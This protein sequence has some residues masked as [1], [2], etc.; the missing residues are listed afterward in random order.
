ETSG[1]LEALDTE[2]AHRCISDHP[3][4]V[5]A[6][7]PGMVRVLHALLPVLVLS[8]VSQSF[9]S[10][11]HYPV[12][13]RN[14][15]QFEHL[16]LHPEPELG[17]IYV[18]A[19]DR[20]FR[21]SSD[22]HLEEEVKTGP[23][24]DSRECLP[25]ISDTSCPLA[26]PTSNH[27]KLLL[28]DP[29]SKVLISCGSVHQGTC[30]KRDLDAIGSV[31]FLA[32]RP[33]DTQ[34]V[35]ANDPEVS[36]VGLVVPPHGARQ[37]V[38]YVGRGYTSS[39]PPISTRNLD[40]EPIFS[41]EETAKLTVVGRLSEYDHHFVA[42][43]A[44]NSHVYFLFYRRDLKS[45]GRDYQT[46][47]SRVCLDDMAY[48]SYVEVPLSCRSAAGKKYN[49]L[50]AARLGLPRAGETRGVDEELLLG[51]FSTRSASSS[52][53]SNESALC[54][55]SLQELNKHIDTTRDLCYT[56]VGHQDGTEAA[57]IEYEVKSNCA[58]LPPTTLE[59][60][61]CGSDHTPSPMA[62][63]VAVEAEP[64]LDS[65]SARLTAVAIS[66]KADHTIAFLGDSKGHLHK[67]FLGPN[68][69]VE[70]YS[71]ISIQPNAAISSELTLD[72]SE[73]HLYIMTSTMLQKRPVAECHLHTDC[74]S[75]LSARDPYCGWCV[76]EGRCGQRGECARG[77]QGDQWLWSF[78]MEQQCLTV[79]TITPSNI[80]N[81]ESRTISL[82]IP[83]LPR[84]EDGESYSCF[85]Q[86]SF[87]PATITES[88]V[89]CPSPD[90]QR[91]PT[92]SPGH[93]LVLAFFKVPA[94]S[95]PPS[96]P[97]KIATVTMKHALHTTTP[98]T[99]PPPTPPTTTTAPAMTT[100]TTT[101][102]TQAT[103]TTT[104]PVTTTTN[105]PATTSTPTTLPI[106][107]E[108]TVAPTIPVL[109]T[110]P[111]QITT[112]TPPASTLP[113]LK[114]RTSEEILLASETEAEALSEAKSV[115]IT[116]SSL[117]TGMETEPSLIDT[118]DR[119]Q[120]MTSVSPTQTEEFPKEVTPLVEPVTNA[121]ALPSSPQIVEESPPLAEPPTET[122]NITESLETVVEDSKPGS[123]L[124][125][126]PVVLPS[127]LPVH[128]EKEAE[129][130]LL[131]IPLE[132]AGMAEN[133][134]T[135]FSAATVLSGDGELDHASPGYPRFPDVDSETDYQ[136]DMANLPGD[137]GSL[138][139]WGSS[140]CPCV[141]KVQGSP[142]L[143]V[144]TERKI[145]LLARNLH[146][147][148]DQDLEYECVLVI[149]GQTVV[150]DAYVERDSR[151]HTLFDITCQHHQYSYSALVEEYNAM[152]YVKRRD[153]F[154]V[155]SANDLFV[156]L[157][158]CSVGRS[159]CSRCHTADHKYDCVWCGEV[160]SSC[161]HKEACL[162]T[163]VKSTCPAP[164]IHFIEPLTGLKEGGTTLR[165]S[166]SNL[167]QKAHDI[168]QS[169]TVAGISCTVIPELYEISSRIVCITGE[170]KEERSGHVSVEVSG[171]GHKGLSIQTFSY[172]EPVLEGVNPQ[173]GPQA[174]GTS[175]TITGK[176]LLTGR[177]SD[178]SVLL[179]NVPCVIFANVQEGRI[180]CVTGAS[181]QTGD[182]IVT[183][184][185]GNLE[186]YLNGIHFHYTPNPNITNAKP[187]KSFISGGRLI[188]VSGHNL[189]VVQEPRIRVTMTRKRGSRRRR[190]R[191]RGSVIAEGSGLLWR[192]KRIIPDVDSAENTGKYDTRWKG[193]K[194]RS[195][196]A[197]FKLFYYGVDSKRNGVGVVLKEE[198]VSNVL[199]VKRVSDR[200]M[201]LKL[202]IEGVMLN[203][204]SGYAPQ[205]RILMDMLVRGTEVMGK[206]GVKERNLEGQMVVDF[207]KRMDMAVVNTYFQ[208]REE[209]RVT[210]KS[211]GR[212]TQVDY[213]LCRRG[214]L[215]EISDCKVFVGES[216]ARQHR[217][218]VCRMTLMVCKT[219]RS[220][221]EKKTKWWKL[222]KEECCEE[223]RQKLRQALG[224]QVVLPDDWE[225]TAEVIRET[226]RKVLGVSSGRRKEDKETWWWNEE[227]QD[228]IQ[229]K[230][231][232]KKKWDIDRTEENRQEYKESQR[233]VKREV[234]KAKQKAYDELYTRLDTR[235]GEKGLY[236]LA[237]QRDR[238]GKD[239]Q[240][241][242][243]IKDRDGRVLT[244]EESVQR[245]WKEYFEE[246]MNEENE[247]E[248]R[249]EGANSVEQKVDKIRKDEVRKALKRMKSGKA[250]GP[251]DIPVEVWKCLG[252]V[253]VEFLT[254]LFNRD[255][256][257]ERM[258]EEWRSVLVPIF[259]NKGDVQSCSNYRGIKLMSHTMKLW[260]RVVQ[261]SE[262]VRQES[263]WTMLFAD[264]I[265]ICSESREQV[266]ENLERW[267]FALERRG[268]K[269]S[270]S[271]TEYMCVNERERSGTVRLQGEEVKK[272]QEFKYL[273]ST[274]QSNGECGKEF[275]ERCE[276]NN[277]SLLLC[278]SPGVSSEV[279]ES[280]VLVEFL[281][282][283]LRFD[284]NSVNTLSSS[285]TYEP[286]PTLTH[287]N[288]LYPTEPYRYKPGS[289]ISVEGQNLDLAM[290]K[291]E[292][293]A[294]IGEGICMVKTL[295]RNHLYCEP[296]AQQPPPSHSHG[297]KELNE[298]PEF[299]VQMG[300][301]NFSLGRVQYDTLSQ[302]TFPLEAQIGVGAVASLVVLIVVIIVLIYRR[303]S[304]QAL[305][306]Y[307][308]VQ[309]QLE[310]LETSVRD[311]CKKEFT[312]LMTEMMD[313]SSDLVVSG[314]PFL[315]YK[316]YAERIFFPGHRESPLRRD[317]DVQD[318]R[319]ATVEQGL[320]QLS[321]LLNSKLFLTKFIHTLE[322]QRTFSPRDRGYVA[323]LLT[324]ALHGKLE[325]FTDILKTLLND[326][327]E[328]YVAKNPKLM[329]R[330]TETVVEKLLTNW[331]SICLYSFLRDS[332][333]ECLYMLFR[334]IK[335]QV[336]KG[337]VDA[338]TG[339]AKYTLNDSRLLREDLEYH[340]L[341]LNVLMQGVG[342]NE[343]Q[344]VA[345]KV[346][347]CDT[348]TQVKEK[349]LDQVFKGTSYSH[350]PHTDSLDLEWRS[351]VAGHLILSDEDL[352]S[353][354]QGN[355]KR[356]NTIQHYKVPDGATVALVPR[357][358]KHIHHD[359]H[360]YVAGEKTPML[361]DAD[362]GGVRLWHLVKANEEPELPKHRRGSL[363]ER[364]RA[365][366]I[367]EIYLTR[368]LSM[369]GTLQKFVDDLFTVILSTSRPVPL[370]VKYFFD[371]LDDQ[372]THHGISDPETIHI[373]K[374][375]SLPLR[376][377]INIVK[378]PQ[379]IFDVQASD[380]VDAVLSVIA[381]TFMDSCT[382]AEHKLGRDSPINKLLYA[383]DIPRYKQMV[384]RYYAD[385][386]QTIPASDQE[387]NSALAEHS[388]TYS[389]ELNYLVAL[390][391]LYK[392]INKYY[393]QII[394]ALE[395][396]TTAQKMQ[397]GYRL[398][399]IAAAVENKV[400]DL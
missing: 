11:H 72:Q 168:L 393:D 205:E 99:T 7:L 39:Q 388:R 267:R 336:D 15:T 200:V 318:C 363:K 137:E 4:L 126:E 379:F 400:T 18:G 247:R 340:T 76:L 210:Y 298:L 157:Y 328:Q 14:Y 193:S 248:K 96:T 191:N 61:P 341:T 307:K 399:Q 304:K 41:Y 80:S 13:V 277:S 196:G 29:Y 211:G 387:M 368:L 81:E 35:A 217:M 326:L 204:V 316:M 263:P 6:M 12:F 288:H 75:C 266:E 369:K 360:D 334:A 306:D 102:T 98:P 90:P 189:D 124:P 329:L 265:V 172:Q 169:V 321:N 385:I 91:L 145:N 65:P 92:V 337:P 133:D 383:R 280:D 128:S 119:D 377:W 165:I 156:T 327:V 147:Y 28:I 93:A 78:D 69:E 239:V 199:E 220:K 56:K 132:E 238:D 218:V 246:L 221:I 394:T 225:T 202:E 300:N 138:E 207:A 129:P 330:R 84:L 274:V 186:R 43:F 66:I 271:K 348:I 333:G 112:T 284:F 358:S 242:R 214:N 317:L 63:K 130:E 278:R 2:A 355:W 46:Y 344:P 275:E 174:G 59:A 103:T 182:H 347:D 243:V 273:G 241:V 121:P 47:V 173:R 240:Q 301:L 113:V 228:S 258:P 235:E 259:K 352:T 382:I 364:E 94:L 308:K 162:N 356:L 384:E 20:L 282:D 322:S 105:T 77:E 49:L 19:R 64:I 115:V 224:G 95:P 142:L 155:D 373:W 370:A 164:V 270:H 376:F 57:Y 33:V 3:I 188:S 194:A 55:F 268:M 184:R 305:R 319:R 160:Q 60:Y 281:L 325:Y 74:Q 58:S 114:E 323:S 215:K 71:I 245:R 292:V 209:H 176:K 54:M 122:Q 107:P 223:F 187:A 146:L 68:G 166:G 296:P 24:T 269:V 234:S 208:K 197:G 314:I 85:F 143:P 255:L 175:L 390:H 150:V 108:P 152:V 374:T 371:L 332:A 227:V 40:T 345:A 149:E 153:T 365:K 254:S 386:R 134:T 22:L 25:P 297:R 335:H 324:V 212:R 38:L 17:R 111:S 206:F 181:N 116:I 230:R 331:M 380:N 286:N 350:R 366:A 375:N 362:E 378:N 5:V 396:D 252:E 178:I 226:G 294:L 109:P 249:V 139:G 36:T 83:G 44:H 303:K 48:Y 309:I 244:S 359:N 50:Q 257:S 87:S 232:A 290:S 120:Q 51:V 313:M 10:P 9:P 190:R 125:T 42:S 52:K 1:V 101:P 161:V 159:D 23:V 154:H 79:Q 389:G 276:V 397:L 291:E 167:G 272:V 203:V 261:L 251:D 398:Q 32:Q 31:L 170:S 171:A 180:E 185:Y 299:T 285:F 192:N 45:D 123:L 106:I 216:V 279:L 118:A 148:Q 353:V 53:P 82:S 231:L 89:T 349:I 342:M 381:Q 127:D 315:D 354:V 367:P 264:D 219:K 30:Q 104:T 195:I 8:A 320:V 97:G 256:E 26:Q 392:Y 213:I 27:N 62:S 21:L 339:K 37:S 293:V 110:L 357:N 237:R 135:S 222:K 201:S 343:T 158:N 144:Q 260:E 287:L 311:R 361:E 86:D 310:N 70:E 73:E 183:V 262:E 67:V 236:R 100:T 179:G 395:E 140:A 34:Y 117:D 391:E 151:N 351:G 198:F 88:G 295:T 283:N 177:A 312:D 131:H 233:R 229:R 141:D 289:V 302:S 163:K 338:V 253:A 16:A 136:Y 250:V 372:A 346:L